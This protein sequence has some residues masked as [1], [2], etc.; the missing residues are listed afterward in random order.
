MDEQLKQRVLAGV[1]GLNFTVIA[2]N[3]VLYLMYG[4][5][6]WGVFFIRLLISL[7]IGLVVGGG[8]FVATQMSQK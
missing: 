2:Y 8:A 1:A 3:L 5:D 7:G 6:S 4:C